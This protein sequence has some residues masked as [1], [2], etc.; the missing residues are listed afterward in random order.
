MGSFVGAICCG[1]LFIATTVTCILGLGL[2]FAHRP[3]RVQDS[4][5]PR[6]RH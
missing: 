2:H 1:P 4:E 3:I 5:N 6:F